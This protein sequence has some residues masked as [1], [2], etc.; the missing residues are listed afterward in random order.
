VALRDKQ[1]IIT[2]KNNMVNTICIGDPVI[3]TH[4]QIDSSCEECSLVG[5]QQDQICFKYGDKIPIIN[6]FQSL[7]GNAPNVA[8]ALVELGLTSTLIS[9]VGNDAY[10]HLAL[11]ELSKRGVATN[12][13]TVDKKNQTRYSIVLNYQAERTILSYSEKK[14]YVWPKEFPEADW[15]Y[16]TG[17]SAGFEPIQKHLIRHLKKHENVKLA[18]NPGSYLLKYA[19]SAIQEILP[20]TDLLIVNLEEAERILKTTL[21]KEKKVAILI[22]KLLARG[23]KEVVLTDGI[24][25][26][27]AGTKTEVW[28]L[29]SFPIEV[30][31][32]TGAGDSFSA[33]YIAAKFYGEDIPTSLLWGT[34]NSTSVIQQH[35]PHGGLLDKKGIKKILQKFSTIVPHKVI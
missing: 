8:I 32:K 21:D 26:S 5:K 3:D 25:G 2:Q 31:A 27:Y 29:P 22:Q 4:V 6:S 19:P 34:A 14:N 9:T 11:D 15:I 1:N 35:G 30:V 18:V 24:N 10:G 33:A 17:L 28:R 13:V 16:Y 20:L 23:V 12:L 7:G